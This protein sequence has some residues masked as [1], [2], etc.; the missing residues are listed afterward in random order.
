[1]QILVDTS[2]WVDYFGGVLSRETDH[3]HGLLGQGF[4][5]TGDLIVAEVLAG[6]WEPEAFAAARDALD[7]F[8]FCKL[9]GWEIAVSAAEHAHRLRAEHQ[10][11][12]ANPVDRLIAAYCLR[13]DLA[14]LHSDP[15]F[16]P[17]AEHLGLKTALPRRVG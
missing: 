17:Y 2:V 4:L 1:M 8:L 5:L 13:W 14:L 10:V 3:L 11:A 12:V 7:R 9:G 6:Y 15:A 16:E